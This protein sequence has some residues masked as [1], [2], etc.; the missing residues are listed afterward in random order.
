MREQTLGEFLRET[1]VQRKITLDDIE[2]QTGI[3]SHYLLALELDQF[4]IIPQILIVL[5]NKLKRNYIKDDKTINRLYFLQ[6]L[7]ILRQTIR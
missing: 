1:R 6:K 4:K 2:S 7:M 3:S 5:Q